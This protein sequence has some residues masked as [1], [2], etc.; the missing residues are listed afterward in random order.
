MKVTL[1]VCDVNRKNVQSNKTFTDDSTYCY[2]ELWSNEYVVSIF[3][4]SRVS[5]LRLGITH[6][7]HRLAYMYMPEGGACFG[8]RS[9]VALVL[10]IF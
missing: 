8:F 1:V 3:R 4:M 10:K 2:V 5:F 7:G 9:Q 6:H